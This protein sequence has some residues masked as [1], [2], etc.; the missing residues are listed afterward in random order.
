MKEYEWL[1][2][3]NAAVTVC[4]IDGIIIY[5]NQKSGKTFEK[6]GG[7]DLIGKSLFACHQPHSVEMI[8]KMMA[9]N[10]TNTY[11][12][13]KAGIKK[14]IYQTPWYKEDKVAGMVEISI[15]IPFEMPHFIR[16]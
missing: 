16:S 7:L 4:D 14:I 1:N 5:M 6:W 11:T 9:E 2:Q 12:I 3:Y 10:T 8:K 15:E 13:E